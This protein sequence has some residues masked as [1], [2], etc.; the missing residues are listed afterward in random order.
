MKKNYNNK[1]TNKH[2]FKSIDKNYN[3]ISVLLK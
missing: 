1:Y 2:E 3:S